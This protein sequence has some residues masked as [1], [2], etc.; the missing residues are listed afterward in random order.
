MTGELLHQERWAGKGPA[1]PQ[2]RL[3][4]FTRLGKREERDPNDQALMSL[5]EV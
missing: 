4:C 1:R 2:D 5:A 3:R